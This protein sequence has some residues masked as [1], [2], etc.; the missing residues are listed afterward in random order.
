MA[1]HPTGCGLRETE[2]TTH[3]HDSELVAQWTT[4]RLVNSF[5][6]FQFFEIVQ[7]TNAKQHLARL[8]SAPYIE[9]F[10]RKFE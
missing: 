6:K 2:K 9:N 4:V 8:L 5:E 1:K 3:W 10:D 7:R